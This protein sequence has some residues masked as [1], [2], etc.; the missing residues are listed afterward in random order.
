MK[1]LFLLP[2][3]A[4]STNVLAATPASNPHAGMNLPAVT[5][6]AAQPSQ[7]ATVLSTVSAPPYIYIEV[8]QDKK[9]L[10]LAATSVAVKKGD[11]IQFAPDMALEN[12][13]SK[14]LKR[15]FPS[16]IFVS[17]VVVGGKK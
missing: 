11:V 7:Q 14:T 16:V 2:L 12:F 15:T 13:Y 8:M 10:W 4:L 17:R 9:T 1:T 3:L 6:P 5:A